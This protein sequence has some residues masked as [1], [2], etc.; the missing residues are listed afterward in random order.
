MN[1]A[2]PKT[3]TQLS[4][5]L[6]RYALLI[7]AGTLAERHGCSAYLVGGAVRDL[8]QG[9]KTA[10]WDIM[11][12]GTAATVVTACA[13]AWHGTV[14]THGR[15]GTFTVTLPDGHHVDFS[16]ARTE[17]YAAAGKLPE[18]SFTTALNDLGRR[19]FTINAL[20]VSLNPAHFGEVL[21]PFGGTE[22]LCRGFLRVL[23][24][25]SF[26]DDPT[27]MV[28]LARFAGRG[29][30]VAAATRALVT[31]DRAYLGTVSDE[32][33]REELLAILAEDR[34]SRGLQISARWGVLPYLAP[35]VAKIDARR[36]DGASS[37][38][39]RLAVLTD[40]LR[41]DEFAVLT[42]KLKLPRVVLRELKALRQPPREKPLLSGS[43]LIRMGYTP[44]P[45]FGK[46]MKALAGRRFKTRRAARDYVVDTFP[47]N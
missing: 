12:E 25:R 29:Y 16:T 9:K 7:D 33:L 41:E 40:S 27:R 18:V 37:C 43:D 19:D 4:R 8:L 30:R 5:C 11:V 21:D 28:R 15:F 26:R 22:D 44:G 24:Q 32:R 35:G 13:A 14:T 1:H 3:T 45:E 23:H 34:P 36:I 31:R 6:K 38:A 46:I 10:D 20:A 42:K 47:H 2:Q 17:T 39:Q